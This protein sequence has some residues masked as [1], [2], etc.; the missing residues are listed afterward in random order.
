M[1]L[2][3]QFKESKWVCVVVETGFQVGER[4]TIQKE[5]HQNGGGPI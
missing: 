5:G 1:Q 4:E 2:M 3:H